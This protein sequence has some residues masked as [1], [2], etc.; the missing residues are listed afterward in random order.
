M[1]SP[2]LESGLSAKNEDA[3]GQ[4]SE[5]HVKTLISQMHDLS[6]MLNTDLSIPS[7]SDQS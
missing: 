5:D 3:I 1:S 4:S 7:G 2:S 6:F